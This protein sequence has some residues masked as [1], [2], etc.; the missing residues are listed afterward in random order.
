MDRCLYIALT[1]AN[2]S[3]LSWA[4]KEDIQQLVRLLLYPGIFMGIWFARLKNRFICRS[5]LL[6]L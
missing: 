5:K 6:W 2:L 1:D 3:R 4:E